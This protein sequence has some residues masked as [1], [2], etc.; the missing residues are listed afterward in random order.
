MQQFDVKRNHTSAHNRLLPVV[1][2]RDLVANRILKQFPKL[3]FGFIEAAAS[4]VPYIFHVLRRSVRGD[5]R[6]TARK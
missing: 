4:W 6:R 3:R 1:A 2:C 5:D